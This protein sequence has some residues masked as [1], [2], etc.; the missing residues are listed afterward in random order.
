MLTLK[1]VTDT[2]EKNSKSIIGYFNGV[3]GVYKTYYGMFRVRVKDGQ[4]EE[5]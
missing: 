5:S 4:K 2:G 1:T 3:C